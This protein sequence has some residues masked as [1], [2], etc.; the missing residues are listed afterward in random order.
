MNAIVDM[1]AIETSL[2]RQDALVWQGSPS[3]RAIA[4]DVYHLRLIAAYLGLL[5]ALDAYQAYAKAIPLGKAVHDSV[6]LVVIVAG[7]MANFI[8]L[9]WLTARTTRYT[10]TSGRLT[11]TYGI[12]ISATLTIPYAR[13]AKLELAQGRDGVGDVALT[14]EAGNHMPYLKLWPLARAGRLLHPQPMLRGVPQVAVVAGLFSR[15]VA[16]AAQEKAARPVEVTELA[17]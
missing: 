11:M 13:I 6:P 17:A 16:A 1:T 7:V 4:R 15:A 2:V 5:V 12:A 3:W 10:I 14:L 8:L 9:A